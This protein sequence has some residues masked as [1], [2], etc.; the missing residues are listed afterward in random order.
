M[1]VPIS[2]PKNQYMMQP[3]ITAA[4]NPTTNIADDALRPKD[5]ANVKIVSTRNKAT[6]ALPMTCKLTEYKPIIVRMPASNAGIFS[7]VVKKPVTTPANAPATVAKIKA[8]IRPRPA[9]SAL[10]ATAAPNGKLP[11]TDKSAISRTRNVM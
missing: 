7:L 1:A 2:V 5:S 3:T 11:S 9:T 10:A 4:A 6:L 8:G